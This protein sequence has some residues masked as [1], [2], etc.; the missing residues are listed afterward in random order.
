MAAAEHGANFPMA[1][2]IRESMTHSQL[3]DFA[4]TSRRRLPA[5]VPNRHPHRNLGAYLHPSKKGR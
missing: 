2:H 4:A 5:H 1:R 3:H